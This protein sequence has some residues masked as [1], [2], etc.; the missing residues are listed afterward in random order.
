MQQILIIRRKE[1]CIIVSRQFCLRRIIEITT[2]TK[3]KRQCWSQGNELK[4][5]SNS[6]Q[7]SQAQ[8]DSTPWSRCTSDVVIHRRKQNWSK[9]D[10]ESE[11]FIHF[12]FH[13][14][15]HLFADNA[16]I[17][18]AG[19]L[20]LFLVCRSPQGNNRLR[21]AYRKNILK[22]SY[23]S[24]RS[25]TVQRRTVLSSFLSCPGDHANHSRWLQS[26]LCHVF[27]KVLA[28]TVKKIWGRDHGYT[29]KASLNCTQSVASTWSSSCSSRDKPLSN[30]RVLIM[31]RAAEFI[32][33]CNLSVVTFGDPTYTERTLPHLFNSNV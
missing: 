31:T 15:F 8:N 5:R 13:F 19:T 32:T 1:N 24:G 18:K 6:N 23:E 4:Q 11:L 26:S 16:A 9:N 2:E 10:V 29:S 22:L 25:R 14:H 21:G 30:F 27:G 20:Q 3:F 7:L 33:R 28:N 17:Y 12:S